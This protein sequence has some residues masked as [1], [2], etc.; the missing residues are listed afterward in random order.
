[1]SLVNQNSKTLVHGNK[2]ENKEVMHSA[3]KPLK[4]RSLASRQKKRWL[5]QQTLKDMIDQQHPRMP[6][7]K[8]QG[9]SI[10]NKFDH[11]QGSWRRSRIRRNI[12]RSCV[13]EEETNLKLITQKRV[14]QT[15]KIQ[16][17]LNPLT[18]FNVKST[19]WEG[20]DDKKKF[21]SDYTLEELKNMGFEIIEWNGV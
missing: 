8:L 13:L 20:K 2:R 1:M 12:K 6:S 15:R 9:M 4:E 3:A 7:S 14:D 21:E 11:L 18:D 5:R 10:D 19:V 17:K 16:A